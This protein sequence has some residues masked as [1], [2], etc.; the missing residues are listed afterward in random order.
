MLLMGLAGPAPKQ[1]LAESF[2]LQDAAGVR[3][4][5]LEATG[6]GAATLRLLGPSGKARAILTVGSDGT[7]ALRLHR[8]D[9][10]PA[11]QVEVRADQGPALELVEP[12]GR[13]RLSAYLNPAGAAAL[14][15]T[16]MKGATSVSMTASTDEA[17]LR[18]YQDSAPR[19]WVRLDGKGRASVVL[20]KAPPDPASN[21]VSLIQGPEGASFLL[22][23]KEA[24]L[25]MTVPLEGPVRTVGR[26]VEDEPAT[27]RAEAKDDAP[28]CARGWESDDG[29]CYRVTST[30][31][32]V[33]GVLSIVGEVKLTR[34]AKSLTLQVAPYRGDKP[35]AVC[36]AKL[37]NVP[38]SRPLPF[39]ASCVGKNLQTPDRVSVRIH[40]R[41]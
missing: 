9:G 38:D 26:I 1:L 24:R 4:A 29:L 18:L 37:A 19:G 7:P 35:L 14:S 16:D 2:V 28:A 36:L 3:R 27:Q 41:R 39:E 22:V 5:S 6:D 21:Q 15:V 12:S 31:Q 23:G 32:V 20:L 30:T 10:T 13:V 40:E 33:D 17:S 25:G 11:V 34:P 8:K